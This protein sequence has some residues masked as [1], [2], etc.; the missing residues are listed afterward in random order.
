MI[1]DVDVLIQF[2]KKYSDGYD[3]QEVGEQEAAP[4][5][6]GG[7]TKVPKWADSYTITR[8]K[9]NR[10][11]ASGEKWDTGLKRGAANQIW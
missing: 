3:K 10:L 6:G 7:G 4:A 1:L 2:F 9:A 11:G 5:S 8:G